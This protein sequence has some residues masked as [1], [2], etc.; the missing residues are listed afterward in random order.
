[1]LYL[2]TNLKDDFSR[3]F[4]F[5]EDSKRIRFGEGRERLRGKGG[6]GGKEE[7]GREGI[8]PCDFFLNKYLRF[9]SYKK[10]F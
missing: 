5:P 7:W 1:M 2:K 3:F 9:S 10:P 6:N 4:Y 8:N